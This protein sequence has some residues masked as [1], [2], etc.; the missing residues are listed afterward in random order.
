M[1]SCGH[2]SKPGSSVPNVL[3]L[4]ALKADGFAPRYKP[5]GR[6]FDACAKGKLLLLAPV[7]DRAM[8]GAPPN[9]PT[10]HNG[11]K[12]PAAAR[13]GAAP[14]MARL[15]RS[16]C[17]ALNQ[18]AADICGPGAAALNY[19]GLVPLEQPHSAAP[20]PFFTGP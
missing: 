17:L 20:I 16:Q 13:F 2:Y 4:I 14:Y 1:L 19:A 6:S 18:L 10:H 9:R 7:E 11:A 5:P 3:P 8:Y 12:Q 15:T